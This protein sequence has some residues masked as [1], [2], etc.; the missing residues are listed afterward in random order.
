MEPRFRPAEC[1]SGVRHPVSPE[2]HIL[3]VDDDAEIRRLAGKFLRE[4]GH[5]VTAAQDAREMR[6]AMKAGP[7]DL[8]ILDIMLPGV[9]GLDLCRD[10]RRTSDVPIIM[11]TA[12]GSDVDRIVGLELGADDY[13]AKPFNPRELLARIHAVLRRMRPPGGATASGGTLLAFSGWMLDTRRRELTNPE[14]VVVDLSTGE[15]D[16]LLTFLEHPQRVLTRD[17]LMDAAKNRTATG[18]DRAID[19]QVSRLRKKLESHGG[20]EMV[21]TVRGAGY[22][23]APEVERS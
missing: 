23:F 18:F 21:K 15:Y 17:Q 8:V 5:K 4:H 1:L 11:L 10:I 7:V 3:I 6:E 12:R 9:S 2:G 13:L 22:F 16:L 14:T 20:P 19:I